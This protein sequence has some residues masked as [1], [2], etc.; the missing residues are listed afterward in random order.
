M[1]ARD[2]IPVGDVGHIVCQRIRA[3]SASIR[4]ESRGQLRYPWT[5]ALHFRL[6]HAKDKS[7]TLLTKAL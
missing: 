5:K 2:E 3:A 4:A 6:Y 7:L 1:L